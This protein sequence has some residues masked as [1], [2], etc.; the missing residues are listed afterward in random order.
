MQILRQ[1]EALRGPLPRRPRL[2]GLVFLA[3][4]IAAVA[5]GVA[6]AATLGITSRT[7]GSGKAAVTACDT[8]GLTYPARA[9]DVSSNVTSLTVASIDTACAGA[10]ITVTLADASGVLLNSSSLTLPA[11]GFTGTATLAFSGSAPAAS[12]SSYQVAIVGP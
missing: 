9:V 7:L 10:R 6:A 12:I 4:A 8:T 3:A 11:T 5:A 1:G 2:I